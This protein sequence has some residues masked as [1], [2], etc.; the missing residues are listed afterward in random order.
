MEYFI[1]D[2][3]KGEVLYGKELRESPRGTPQ[4]MRLRLYNRSENSSSIL[5][6]IEEIKALK[7]FLNKLK[8]D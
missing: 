2:D 7:Y 1:H 5:L 3:L 4:E 8:T 6:G